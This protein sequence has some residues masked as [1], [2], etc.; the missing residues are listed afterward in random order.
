[1]KR[2]AF[3]KTEEFEKAMQFMDSFVV[4]DLQMP[5]PLDEDGKGASAFSQEV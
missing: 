1:M 3:T 2:V 5:V 4:D